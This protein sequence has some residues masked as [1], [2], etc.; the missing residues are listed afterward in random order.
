MERCQ[1]IQEGKEFQRKN[2]RCKKPPQLPL[3]KG[4]QS[5]DLTPADAARGR[6][7]MSFCW[8][9]G[10]LVT[11]WSFMNAQLTLDFVFIRTHQTPWE[12]TMI[13][14]AKSGDL[15]IKTL[16]AK[17]W[18]MIMIKKTGLCTLEIRAAHRGLKSHDF[19]V[20]KLVGQMAQTSLA[21]STKSTK[22]P[23]FAGSALLR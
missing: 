1:R 18:N 17:I 11:W 10:P 20:S 23:R 12:F 13:F 14:S 16:I 2:L 9:L 3:W 21:K 22:R 19:E 15:D 7:W 6:Q 8:P 5:R 4:E